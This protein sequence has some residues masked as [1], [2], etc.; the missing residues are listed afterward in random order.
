MYIEKILEQGEQPGLSVDCP[1]FY[2]GEDG[3][4]IIYQEDSKEVFAPCFEI[5]TDIII[6]N[7]TDNH[8]P[9]VMGEISDNKGVAHQLNAANSMV[10]KMAQKLQKKPYNCKTVMSMIRTK[11][12]A[13]GVDGNPK[14]PF[15]KIK[16]IVELLREV[17]KHNCDKRRIMLFDRPRTRELGFCCECGMAWSMNLLDLKDSSE[18]LKK[19]KLNMNT[20]ESRNEIAKKL[21]NF[22]LF[23]DVELSKSLDNGDGFE[24]SSLIYFT[25]L[26]MVGWK[27]GISELNSNKEIKFAVEPD[28]D[29]SEVT[30]H[31]KANMDVIIKD[32][33]G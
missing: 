26:S 21:N 17:Q 29:Y 11:W 20:T 24:P 25:N 30:K 10:S 18:Y 12:T 2:Y 33:E 23:D 7:D 5:S 9:G 27:G 22:S 19:I 4:E 28:F 14:G 13:I 3:N 32:A 6:P 31:V 15:V 8:S 1:V 16:D